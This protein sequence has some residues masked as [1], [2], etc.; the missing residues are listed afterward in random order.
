MLSQKCE[1]LFQLEVQLSFWTAQSAMT[2]T[3]PQ[4]TTHF[5]GNYH[6]KVTSLPLKNNTGEEV[7]VLL[8]TLLC[9]DKLLKIKHLQKFKSL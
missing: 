7:Y 6:P 5:T 8:L 2:M 9:K 4:K 3:S 1:F